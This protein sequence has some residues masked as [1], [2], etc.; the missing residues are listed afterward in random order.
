MAVERTRNYCTIIYPESVFSDWINIL[1]EECVPCLI[2]P[3]HDKDING[4]DE[5]KKPHYHII[6]MFDG[7][8][9]VEQAQQLS[10]RIGGIMVKPVISIRGYARYLTHM[11]NPEKYQYCQDDV[12]QLCGADYYQIINIPSDKYGVIKDMMAFCQEYSI[13]SYAE[14]LEYS[15]LEHMEWFRSLCD[16]STLVIKEYLKSKTWTNKN[17]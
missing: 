8:K 1:K 5:E 15:A 7:P 17:R 13:F 2:S 4:N 10:Y 11:D 16:N 3:L 12:L 6:F 14:L 9:T